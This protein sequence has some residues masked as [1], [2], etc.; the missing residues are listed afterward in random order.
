MIQC[1]SHVNLN[2]AIYSNPLW[3]HGHTLILR[4]NLTHCSSSTVTPFTPHWPFWPRWKPR[5]PKDGSPRG[6]SGTGTAT[7]ELESMGCMKLVLL[8]NVWMLWAWRSF[9][10]CNDLLA[11]LPNFTSRVDDK[12]MQVYA[13]CTCYCPWPIVLYTAN[14]RPSYRTY[15]IQRYIM[16][17]PLG[18]PVPTFQLCHSKWYEMIISPPNM[19]FISCETMFVPVTPE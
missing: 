9:A 2:F 11:F 13:Q 3:P 8:L 14:T 16:A 19:V 7:W 6:S 5:R 17:N 18:L 1:M 4:H 15:L 10:H 12:K